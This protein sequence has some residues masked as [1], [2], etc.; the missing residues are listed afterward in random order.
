MG[1]LLDN[2]SFIPEHYIQVGC[3]RY[4]WQHPLL[5]CL[6]SNWHYLTHHSL[7]GKKLKRNESLQS[8]QRMW[9]APSAHTPLCCLKTSPAS[10]M[11]AAASS[12]LQTRAIRH[13]RPFHAVI[14]QE[15]AGKSVGSIRASLY[16][17]IFL[18]SPDLSA[19]WNKTP[20]PKNNSSHTKRPFYGAWC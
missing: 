2:W 17:C 12:Q 19:S 1:S 18:Q 13:S 4:Y 16:A 11:L 5:E 20:A 8:G 10:Q 6:F 7:E 3:R 14:C 9:H 15:S